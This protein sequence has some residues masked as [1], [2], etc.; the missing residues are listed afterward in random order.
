[1]SKYGS[2]VIFDNQPSAANPLICYI[3]RTLCQKQNVLF[4]RI[5]QRKSIKAEILQNASNNHH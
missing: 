3:I 4:Y 1:M 5:K 2:Q